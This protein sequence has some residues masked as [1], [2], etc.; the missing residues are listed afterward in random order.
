MP[1]SDRACRR[2]A[3]GE[4]ARWNAAT[5]TAA[6]IWAARSGRAR[7]RRHDGVVDA[8]KRGVNPDHGGQFVRI[9]PPHG[10]VFTWYFHLAAIGT[11][12]S[13]ASP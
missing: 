7:A 1:R 9:G 11:I 3:A 10:T 5:A 4:T 2:R 12:S 13:A 8:V 6:W